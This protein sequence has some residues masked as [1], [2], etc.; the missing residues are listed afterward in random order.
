[1]WKQPRSAIA[2]IGYDWWTLLTA[3]VCILTAVVLEVV[4]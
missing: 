1:M 2:V 3:V 4:L